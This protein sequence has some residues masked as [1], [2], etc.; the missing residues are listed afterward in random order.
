MTVPDYQTIML[1]ILQCLA[2]GA[3]RQVVP[4]VTGYHADFC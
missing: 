2:D 1:P 4:D 3:I